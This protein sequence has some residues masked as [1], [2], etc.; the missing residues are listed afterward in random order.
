M[1]IAKYILIL[2]CAAPSVSAQQADPCANYNTTKR[3][4]PVY[5]YVVRRGD[6]PM[7]LLRQ[8][9]RT[10]KYFRPEEGDEGPAK[11]PGAG[12]TYESGIIMKSPNY[13]CQDDYRYDALSLFF[14]A[15][16]SIAKELEFKGLKIGQ[17]IN[18]PDF[19]GDK[20]INKQK[21]RKTGTLVLEGESKS[22][23]VIRKDIKYYPKAN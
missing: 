17:R 14:E 13:R 16:P 22:G 15:N 12:S 3:E 6:S 8:E 11:S 20:M 10:S 18:V 2:A 9:A 21:G 1:G 19:S 23:R 7:R 4:I 5:S